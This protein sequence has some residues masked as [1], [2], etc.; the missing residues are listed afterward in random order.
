VITHLAKTTQSAIAYNNADNNKADN[1]KAPQRRHGIPWRRFFCTASA[2]VIRPIR[3]SYKYRLC[4]AFFNQG[5]SH[6][7][8]PS[9][10]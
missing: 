2:R 3:R 5:R 7:E 8:H 9:P 1:N 10:A 6:D 4:F